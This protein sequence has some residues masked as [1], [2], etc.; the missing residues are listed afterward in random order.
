MMNS[1][2]SLLLTF[3]FLIFFSCKSTDKVTDEEAN[4]IG[5]YSTENVLTNV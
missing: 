1:K 5:D 4:C 2:T 3:I